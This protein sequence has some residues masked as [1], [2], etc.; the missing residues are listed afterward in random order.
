MSDCEFCEGD[1]TCNATSPVGYIC[2]RDDGHTGDHVACD[3]AKH[4][5]AVWPRRDEHPTLDDYPG[6]NSDD[7]YLLD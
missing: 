7:Y 6:E 1:A 3:L 2:T 5:C 4:A